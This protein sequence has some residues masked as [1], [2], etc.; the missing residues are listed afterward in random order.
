ML[1]FIEEAAMPVPREIQGER[2]EPEHHPTE[3]SSYPFGVGQ[4]RMSLGG[5]DEGRHADTD[6]SSARDEH[7]SCEH[8]SPLTMLKTAFAADDGDPKR[9]EAEAAGKNVQHDETLKDEHDLRHP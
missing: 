9:H 6:R 5:V 2:G 3:N 1:G 4:V 7:A 8:L